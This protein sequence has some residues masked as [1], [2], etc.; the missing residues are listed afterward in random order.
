MLLFIF[1]AIFIFIDNFKVFNDRYGHV[2]GDLILAEMGEMLRHKTRHSDVA[3]R[4]GGEEF[5][6]L[7]PN[8]SPSLTFDRADKIRQEVKK[9]QLMHHGQLLDTLSVSAGVAVFPNHGRD[10]AEL[11]CAADEALYRA[12]AGGRDCVFMAETG[13]TGIN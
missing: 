13:I 1:F 3:C 9:M 5:L 4:Y 7:M 12:K 2:A 6:I 8:A 10:V 11:V